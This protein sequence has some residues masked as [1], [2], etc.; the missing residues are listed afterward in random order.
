MGKTYAYD[1]S[2]RLL[3]FSV[4]VIKMLGNIERRRE[5]DVV[6]Y[7]LSKS[8]TSIG[9]NYQESQ[10]STRKEFSSRVRI[11]VR[12]ALETR[13]WIRILL[14]LGL[15]E[16]EKIKAAHQ[17]SEEIIKILKTILRK[18]SADDFRGSQ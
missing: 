12:E 11:C 4:D 5:L 13:Y 15:A 16:E 18:S 7:Q 2:E 14:A 9:A 3:R 10:S 6:K 1:L 17:E 8:V